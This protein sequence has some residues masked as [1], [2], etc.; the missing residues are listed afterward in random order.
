MYIRANNNCS[1]GYIVIIL[2]TNLVKN[3]ETVNYPQNARSY[4]D[5]TFIYN[6]YVRITNSSKDLD[7]YN[8]NTLNVSSAM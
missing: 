1:Q 3:F 4:I 6:L 7:S 5:A 2:S 8:H